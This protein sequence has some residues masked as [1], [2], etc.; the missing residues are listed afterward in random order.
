MLQAEPCVCNFTVVCDFS[1]PLRP[2][3]ARQLDQFGNNVVDA[4]TGMP[5]FA[6]VL[7]QPTTVRNDDGTLTTTDPGG[8]PATAPAYRTRHLAADGTQ[9]SA[10]AYAAALAAGGVPSAYKAAFVGVTYHCG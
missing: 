6:P 10:D 8:E 9:I 5:V 1:A 3:L 2:V 4:A 7:T